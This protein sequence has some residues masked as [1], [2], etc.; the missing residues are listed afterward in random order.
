MQIIS[1]EAFADKKKRKP[2]DSFRVDLSLT[3][4]NHQIL[5]ACLL[6]FAEA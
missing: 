4:S 6:M 3:R 2:T 1:K 5:T